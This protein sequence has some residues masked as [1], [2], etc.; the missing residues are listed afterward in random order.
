MVKKWQLFFLEKVVHGHGKIQSFSV[1]VHHKLLPVV[2]K[3][4]L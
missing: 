3:E 4:T 1:R 2:A